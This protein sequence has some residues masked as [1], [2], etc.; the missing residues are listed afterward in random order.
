[1]TIFWFS[2]VFNRARKVKDKGTIMTL[3]MRLSMPNHRTRIKENESA[4]IVAADTNRLLF[5]DKIKHKKV[6]INMVNVFV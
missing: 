3:V 2:F 6:N 1:M 4:I 5:Y